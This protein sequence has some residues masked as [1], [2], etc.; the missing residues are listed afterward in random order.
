MTS[1]N[2]VSLAFFPGR[3]LAAARVWLGWTQAE[4]AARAG[5]SQ[6]VVSRAEARHACRMTIG[7]KKVVTAYRAAG[8]EILPDGTVRP[9]A[10]E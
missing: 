2:D 7:V 6:Q 9:I 8:V 1:K 4:A 3:W 10:Q 5:T